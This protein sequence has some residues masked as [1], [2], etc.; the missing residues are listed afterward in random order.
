[1]KVRKKDGSFQEFNLEKIVRSIEA[2][3]DEVGEPM[4][5]SDLNN[6]SKEVEKKLKALY[7]DEVSYAEIRDTI[8]NEL[9][10][11]GF[12]D[13]AKSYSDF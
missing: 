9:K 8:V 5:L 6:I 12:S 13:V 2:A 10:S 11:S 7:K 4:T 1:M 3:S